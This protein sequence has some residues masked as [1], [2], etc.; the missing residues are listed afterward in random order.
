MRK[1]RQN[2]GL[3]RVKVAI[4]LL[5]LIVIIGTVGYMIIEDQ[6]FIDSLYMTIITI[7]TVGYGELWESSNAGKIFNIFLILI[8]FSTYAYAISI[9]TSHIVELK[10]VSLLGKGF[11]KFKTMENHVIII[12]FGRNGR[13]VA[14]EL[15]ESET[16]FLVIDNDTEIIS[17]NEDKNIRFLEGDA[18]D[19]DTLEKAGIHKAKAL[20]TTL[21]NDA[22]NLFVVL[23]ARALNERLKIISRAS[24]E[25]ALKKLRVAKVDNVIM[26]EK[27]G[28][29]H[30]A[31]LITQPDIVEF[32][33]QLSIPSLDLNQI[34]EFDLS[35]YANEFIP[36]S[37]RELDLREKTGVNIIGYKSPEGD[38]VINPSPDIK[39]SFKSKLFVL[40]T[41]YQFE[42]LEKLMRKIS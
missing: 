17:H 16:P 18:T 38:Y 28:G 9:I 33:D 4:F 35:H 14:K 5:A 42:K 39:L 2:K 6:N 31:I 15:E 26:P 11:Q 30:M 23:S 20:V 8:S 21:P 24:S 37:I 27:V 40:G 7:S 12:G 10:L 36:R 29:T 41:P 19:D 32:L 13:Q 3:Y 22:N 34:H 1:K 25:N